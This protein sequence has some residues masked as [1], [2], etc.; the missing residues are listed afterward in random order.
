[1]EKYIFKGNSS[2]VSAWSVLT[3]IKVVLSRKTILISPLP[4][5]SISLSFYL[6]TAGE[7]LI[8]LSLLRPSWL[9][10]ASMAF[11]GGDCEPEPCFS[12][13]PMLSRGG[14]R[15]RFCF[16]ELVRSFSRAWLYITLT[17][18]WNLWEVCAPAVDWD[19]GIMGAPVHSCP[20]CPIVSIFSLKSAMVGTFMLQKLT[21]ATNQHLWL[22]PQPVAYPYQHTAACGANFFKDWSD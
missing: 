15:W 13:L 3:E 5:L 2:L 16:P 22:H 14:F 12:K 9:A 6:K 8:F 1:M 4:L 10:P 18:Q 17:C 11:S 19:H 20:H 7:T 21:D